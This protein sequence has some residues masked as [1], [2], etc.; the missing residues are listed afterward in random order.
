MDNERYA[1][2][3]NLALRM[4][5][6]RFL[7][8]AAVARGAT[9]VIPQ[10]AQEA[11]T[12]RYPRLN[13]GRGD[14]IAVAL[15]K[16]LPGEGREDSTQAGAEAEIAII[17]ARLAHGWTEALG[18]WLA[19]ETRRNDA[20]WASAGSNERTRFTAILIAEPGLLRGDGA[21]DQRYGGTGEDPHVIAEAMASGAKWIGSANFD[22]RDERQELNEWL[23]RTAEEAGLSLRE[24]FVLAPEQAVDELVGAL[25][26]G[27][28]ERRAARRQR[29]RLA[30]CVARAWEREEDAYERDAARMESLVRGLDNG[31]LTTTARV[32]HD[33][34]GDAELWTATQMEALE[35]ETKELRAAVRP[36]IESDRRRVE[37]ERS[38]AAE[39]E[40]YMQQQAAFAGDGAE[41]R[42]GGGPGRKLRPRKRI[43]D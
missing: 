15:W 1:L 4:W 2:D 33:E 10:T 37:S 39:V 30:Y 32:I 38:A 23:R 40:Q 36:A 7:H 29:A 6:R 9:L 17:K 20:Y 43:G 41:A 5:V 26:D 21:R 27:G 42:S 3:A 14:Q 19:S 22:K 24:R 18:Q 8:A 31:G 25:P 12:R 34:K 13:T 11:M 16:G 28:P 35:G